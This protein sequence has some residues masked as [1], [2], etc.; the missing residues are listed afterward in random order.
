MATEEWRKQNQEKLRG[1]RRD[2]YA[3]NT[4]HAKQKVLERRSLILS[5]IEDYK[6]KR[7]C[8]RCGESDIRCLDLHHRD[9]SEKEVEI[10][11]I[12]RAKGW[13]QE[14]ILAELAKCDVVCANCHR[15]IHRK[16]P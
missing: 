8:E 5:F 14:R 16:G 15:K 9:P 11:R 4:V 3:R 7:Q 12:A 2:W 1:Y 6:S 10:A 13:K